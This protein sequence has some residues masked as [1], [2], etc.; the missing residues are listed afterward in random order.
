MLAEAKI[1]P[2]DLALP[3]ISDSV[4]ETCDIIMRSMRDS[5]WRDQHEASARRVTR[6]V[7]GSFPQTHGR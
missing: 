4:E 1:S 5:G 6:E 7:L 3:I 2:A